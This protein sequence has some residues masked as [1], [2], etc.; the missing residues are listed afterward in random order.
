MAQNSLS[1]IVQNLEKDGLIQRQEGERDKRVSVLVAMPKGRQ[2]YKEIENH[3]IEQLAK[4]L[5]PLSKSQLLEYTRVLTKFVGE[6]SVDLPPLPQQLEIHQVKSKRSLSVA[7]GFL[8]RTSVQSHIE[9]QLPQTIISKNNIIFNIKDPDDT[10]MAVF[11]VCSNSKHIVCAGWKPH[12]SPWQL[13]AYVNATHQAIALSDEI[14]SKKFIS[15]Q[16]L[17]QYLFGE[18]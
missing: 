15:Y 2:L 17:T 1:S 9:E 14:F 11:E 13:L 6:R 3:A 7:R 16:P 4:A 12:I 8:V 10:T 18:S 5:N